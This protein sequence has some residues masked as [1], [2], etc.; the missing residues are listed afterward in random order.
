MY[1]LIKVDPK[2]EYGVARLPEWKAVRDGLTRNLVAFLQHHRHAS[3]SVAADHLLVKLLQSIAV[4]HS[5][6]SDRYYSN[7]SL[8]ALAV[9]N[10]LQLTTP[11]GEGKLFT[12]MFFNKQVQ[13]VVIAFDEAFDYQYV[14]QHWEDATPVR[15]VR[16]P[17]PHVTLQVPNGRFISPHSGVSV[18][19]VNVAL[20]AV[21]HR[22]F[23]LAEQYKQQTIPGYVQRNTMQF[24]HMFVLPNMLESYLDYAI[25]NRID[26]HRS[27]QPMLML[28]H[29]S[30]IHLPN[31]TK[32]TDQT[33]LRLLEIVER[34]D[35]SPQQLLAA[36]PAVTLPDMREVMCVPDVAPTRQILWSVILA[37]LPMLLFL[38]RVAQKTD[39]IRNQ[40]GL[41]DVATMLIRLKNQRV[42]DS[43]LPKPLY[44][45]AMDTIHEI[46]G[47]L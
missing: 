44:T 28:P 24:I 35:Y 3:Y 47:Y 39:R 4:P 18:V 26:S 30:T 10:S 9:A 25:F 16:H 21:Q 41:A 6:N 11:F 14:E 2:K 22:A 36:I 20:L 34:S 27:G 1:S 31:Y 23:C 17:F 45:P 29:K 33:L 13:E 32:L 19:A 46:L 12:G 38:A 15:V 37:R 43:T 8:N 5:L 7:I 42:L 40:T